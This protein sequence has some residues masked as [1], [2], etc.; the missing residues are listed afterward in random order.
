MPTE[1]LFAFVKE[2]T[3]VLDVRKTNLPEKFFRLPH[4]QVK[5]QK[6]EIRSMLRLEP[7]VRCITGLMYCA[8]GAIFGFKTLKRI[9]MDPL[10]FDEYLKGKDGNLLTLEQRQIVGVQFYR[11]TKRA[12]IIEMY[13]IMES[14]VRRMIEDHSSLKPK[15]KKDTYEQES[16]GWIKSLPPELAPL[17]EQFADKIGKKYIGGKFQTI[18]R[19]LEC[20]QLNSEQKKFFQKIKG[21]RD[22]AHDGFFDENGDEIAFDMNEFPDLLRQSLKFVQKVEEIIMKYPA[23]QHPD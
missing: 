4:G 15:L 14:E 12:A 22:A 10:L 2:C 5:Q 9:G 18:H 7:A 16:Q 11:H 3:D 19:Y 6:N 17:A 21:L 23:T 1:A 8:V 20:L 13:S